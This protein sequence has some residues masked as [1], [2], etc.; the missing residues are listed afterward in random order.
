MPSCPGPGQAVTEPPTSVGGLPGTVEAPDAVGGVV[1]ATPGWGRGQAVTEPPTAWGAC[2][3][4]WK[5]PTQSGVW[6]LLCQGGIEYDS[7]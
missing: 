3:G 2:R 5:P 7:E 1:T 6:S 4:V